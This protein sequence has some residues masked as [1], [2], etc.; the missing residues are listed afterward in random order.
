VVRGWTASA[1]DPAAA[2]S[3]LPGGDVDVAGVLRP[4]EPP[5]ERP[6]GTGSGLPPGQLDGVDLTQLVQRWPDK[7]IT[8]YLVLTA[9]RPGPTG[10]AAALTLVPPTAPGTDDLAWQNLSYALQW[11]GFAGFG[12]FMWWRLVRDDHYG[13]LP[14]AGHTL[15]VHPS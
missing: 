11:F 7:L 12:V 3:G 2:P 15:P 14:R 10:A 9:Q 6:P 4:S 13:R 8:G 1:T 5:I